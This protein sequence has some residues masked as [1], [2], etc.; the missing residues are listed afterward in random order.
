MGIEFHFDFGSP[1]AYLAHKALPAIA[2]ETGIE[3]EYA[4]VLLGGLFRATDN[5]SP[6][7]S[8]QGIENKP[9]YQ[10]VGTRRCA[11]PRTADAESA[12]P[13]QYAQDHARRGTFGSPTLFVGKEIFFGRGKLRDVVEE[14]QRA[15]RRRYHRSTTPDLAEAPDERTV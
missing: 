9:Q 2:R 11:W 8:L 13:R 3:F 5:V 10:A 14:A 7:V 6:A 15:G 1:N 12:L 4:P